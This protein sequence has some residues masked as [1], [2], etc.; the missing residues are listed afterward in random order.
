LATCGRHPIDSILLIAVTLPFLLIVYGD[1]YF[2]FDAAFIQ[3]PADFFI[4]YVFPAVAVIAFWSA[5]QAT[6][7]K[8]VIGAKIVDASTSHAPTMG[9]LIGRYLAYFLSTIALFLG[10]IWVAVDDRKQG[11]HDKLAGTVV[12]RLKNRLPK[13]VEFK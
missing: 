3:G 9:Q 7:G 1:G 8:M 2:A 12:V 5:K 13:K 4:S 6:P 10:F 11:W